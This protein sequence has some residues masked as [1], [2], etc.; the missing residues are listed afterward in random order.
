VH[1]SPTAGTQAGDPR[2]FGSQ[3][4]IATVIQ[5]APRQAPILS[6]ASTQVKPQA[7]SSLGDPAESLLVVLPK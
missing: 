2:A 7:L 4:A 6:V 3:V 5:Q 1:A